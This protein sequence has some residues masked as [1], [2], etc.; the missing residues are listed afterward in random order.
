M[1]SPKQLPKLRSIYNESGI[2]LLN[3][4]FLLR[5][6]SMRLTG[7]R[8]LIF[9][10]GTIV[11]CDR[12]VT[13]SQGYSWEITTSESGN[14]LDELLSSQKYV[15][16][17]ITN[18]IDIDEWNPSSHNHIPF[19]YLVDDLSGKCKAALQIELVLLVSGLIDSPLI[20]FIED[21][22]IKWALI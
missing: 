16:H 6:E 11:T 2:A 17:G 5:L 15:L 14:G 8:Q 12:I 22:T 10:R 19:H 1:I 21:W 9:L 18:G 13:V 4:F 3:G 7:V 20:G